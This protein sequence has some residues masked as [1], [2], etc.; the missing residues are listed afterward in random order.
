MDP[1]LIG[2][3]SNHALRLMGVVLL[4][5]AQHG[6]KESKLTNQEVLA[7]SG[8]NKNMLATAR[9]EL[10][11]FG[12]LIF[13]APNTYKLGKSTPDWQ[14]DV[15]AR[16]KSIPSPSPSLIGFETPPLYELAVEDNAIKPSKST[17]VKQTE[18]ITKIKESWPSARITTYSQAGKLLEQADGDL[19]FVME[20][21]DKCTWKK[22]MQTPFAYIGT[23][24]K[25]EKEKK[26][27]QA[28]QEVND[29]ELANDL[30]AFMKKMKEKRNA[31]KSS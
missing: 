11:A 4:D 2:R 10:I 24:I 3:L 15:T 16:L 31:N 19:D 26:A 7:M 21:I 14:V 30:G 25:S 18:I 9:R 20:C 6:G 1:S 29:A 27:Q 28:Q 5:L 23:V 17:K 12:L 8:I 22:N 13:I